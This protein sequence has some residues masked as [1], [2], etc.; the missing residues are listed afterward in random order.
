ML[1]IK[2]K[3]AAQKIKMQLYEENKTSIDK[4]VSNLVSS[5]K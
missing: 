4:Q 5:R 1:S 2:I 3:T